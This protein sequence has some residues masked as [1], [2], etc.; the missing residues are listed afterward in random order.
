MMSMAANWDAETYL[1]QATSK[2]LFI[3]PKM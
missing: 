3:F 2:A 1:E